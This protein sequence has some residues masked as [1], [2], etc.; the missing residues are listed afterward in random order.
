MFLR[1]RSDMQ[2][3]KKVNKMSLSLAS[4]FY[5]KTRLT[6]CDIVKY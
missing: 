4:G 2:T 5:P 6:L 1:I 3:K